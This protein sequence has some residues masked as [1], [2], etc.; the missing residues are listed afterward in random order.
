MMILMSNILLKLKSLF[1]K[2]YVNFDGYLVI[3]NFSFFLLSL[4]KYD[5]SI[6]TNSLV[7]LLN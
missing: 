1:T 3:P 5:A 6:Y 7:K 2:F 4:K